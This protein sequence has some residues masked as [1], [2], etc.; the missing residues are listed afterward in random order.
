MALPPDKRLKFFVFVIESPSPLDLYHRRSEGEIIQQAVNL[1]QIPCIVKT[2]INFQAFEAS[3]KIGL[4][5]AMDIFPGMI[6]ILHISAHG[7]QD[8]IELS[9]GQV[10]F[11]AD[12]RQLLQAVNQA[13][14]HCLIVCLSCCEGYSGVRMAMFTEDDGYPFFAIVA[15][16]SKPLWAETAIGYA[17]FYH[18]IAKGAYIVD[19]VSAMRV[20]SG[21]EFF[22]V[23]TAEEARKSYLDYIQSINTQEVQQQ[24][25]DNMAKEEPDH[26]ENLK[27]VSRESKP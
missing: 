6:P 22:W 4:K 23:Q 27:K 21:N 2:A 14:N 7:S 10:I 8:G 5:E 12:L 17:T 19:A 16:S 26:L 3:L 24:L 25:E 20:A 18:L 1:N 11:W 15:N 13:L 9:S